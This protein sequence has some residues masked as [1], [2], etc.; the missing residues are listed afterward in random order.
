MVPVV[1]LAPLQELH[2]SSV[3]HP[4]FET[5]RW[6]LNTRRVPVSGAADAVKAAERIDD[7]SEHITGDAASGG[8]EHANLLVQVS[9]TLTSP[10]GY[11][12]IAPV[13]YALSSPGCLRKH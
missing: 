7:L 1:P 9:E 6:L 11:V 10:H 8:T 2:A 12:I 4:R 13:I 3:Q 5:M